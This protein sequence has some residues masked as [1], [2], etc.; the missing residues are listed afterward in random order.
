MSHR[1]AVFIVGG[2]LAG[3]LGTRLG[4][5]EKAGLRVGGASLLT[6]CVRLL[7]RQ[8]DAVTL[9]APLPSAEFPDTICDP[10]LGP[11]EAIATALS[12][13]PRQYSG[14]T[15][16]LTVSVDSYLL[17]ADFTETMLDALT[18]GAA[19]VAIGQFED[20]EYPVNALWR[21][22]AVAPAARDGAARSRGRSVRSLYDD[23]KS[24]RVNFARADGLD[25]FTNVNTMHDLVTAQRHFRRHPDSP[26]K[27]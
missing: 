4:H 26:Q 20:N 16:L 23:L 5:V 2:I 24:T 22:E 14:A 17:P 11:G 25:P 27:S 6:R 13:M 18:R 10:G 15:H 7:Q 3:G 8:C 9:I 12:E 21:L 1:D 19:D